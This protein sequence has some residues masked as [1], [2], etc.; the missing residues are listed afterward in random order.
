MIGTSKRGAGPAIVTLTVNP[1]VDI[2]TSVE[3]IAPFNKLRCGPARRD[4]GGGGINVARVLGRFGM[5]AKAIYPAGGPTGQILQ[6]LLKE[7]GIESLVIP[8]E[9]ETREDF[10]V[11]ERASGKQFR[12]IL[13]GPPLRH[14]EYEA[15]LDA[16]ERCEPKPDFVIAS[17]SLPLGVPADFLARAACMTAWRGAKLVL[18][19]SGPAFRAALAGPI[20]LIKPNLREFYE[21]MQTP[22]ETEAA[23]LEAART[24]LAAK[25]VEIIALTLADQGALLVT[26]EAAWRGRAPKLKPVS[27]VG[28]GDS[29]LGALLWRL[30]QGRALDDALRYGIAAGSA[31]LLSEGTE[32]CRVEDVE[33]LLPEIMIEAV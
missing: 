8:I 3:R 14:E 10:S 30:I 16:L 33:N 13:P 23:Q 4:P 29:F 1:A 27:T 24:L 22:L 26:R 28:A 31:A 12:F 20:Y 2:S 5:E 11:T 19:S 15:L 17:G 7:E 18:D 21:L 9:G 32:L 6:R 25:N